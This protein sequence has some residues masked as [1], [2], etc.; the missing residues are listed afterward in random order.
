MES[1]RDGRPDLES[2]EEVLSWMKT[3]RGVCRGGER[4]VRVFWR[5]SAAFWVVR[6]S[7]AKRF[8][9]AEQDGVS[10]A[11]YDGGTYD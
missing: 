3:F 5:R 2:S 7:M 9:I 8:G 6:V 1:V 11:S 10:I 4:V